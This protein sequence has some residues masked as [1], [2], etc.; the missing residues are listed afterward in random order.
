MYAFSF[1]CFRLR[2]KNAKEHTAVSLEAEHKEGKVQ[3]IP[4]SH[5]VCPARSI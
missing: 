1:V 4:Y 5:G 3:Y 2:Q